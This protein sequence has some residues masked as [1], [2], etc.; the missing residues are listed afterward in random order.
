MAHPQ[1]LPARSDLPGIALALTIGVFAVVLTRLL[2]P[3]PLLSDVLLA[4][5]FGAVITNVRPLR[6]L[7]GLA[8]PGEEREA[9]R[10]ATGLRFVGKWV[11][12]LS[13]ILMGLKLQAKIFGASE[14]LV[15][16]MVAAASIP[17]AFLVAHA[18]AAPLGVRRPLGDLLAGG[19]M[20]CGASAVNALAPVVGARREE[21]GVAIG[22]V[23]LFSVVALVAFHPIATL[24][25]LD[26]AHAGL[27]S[28]LA[29]NDLSSAV[30]VGQQM[31]EAGGTMA[32][33][34][35]SSRIVLMA[36]ML[37]VLSL[38]RR[39]AAPGA[40]VGKRALDQLPGFLLG[41]VA[42]AAARAAIDRLAPSSGAVAAVLSGNRLVVDVLMAT[43]TASI[44]LHLEGGR[45]LASGWR[46][47]AVGGATA[48]WMA[49]LTLAMITLASRGATTAAAV[50]GG[51]C[52]V[53][54]GLA[55]RAKAGPRA[56]VRLV[57]QRYAAGDALTVAEASLLLDRLD[58]E[59]A[60][61][62]DALRRVLRLLQPS[63]GELIPVRASPLAHGVGCRWATF[64]EGASG[65]ALVAVCRDPGSA[66]PIHAHPHRLLGKSIEGI[67]EE[68]RFA[69]VGEG[70]L[71]LVERKALTHGDLVETDGLATPH[72]VRALGDHHTIDMQLRGPESGSPGRRWQELDAVD[73]ERLA[74]G[75]EVV[76]RTEIDDRPGQSGDGAAAGRL[77]QATPG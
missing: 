5:A 55:Y 2:P 34:A 36:P 70:R 54:A 48:A 56:E 33:A 14:L 67:L 18:V 6:R 26:A 19:T 44:G 71:R 32:A 27:W 76:T 24:V 12:R 40:D 61:D 3:S 57:K 20:I 60:L 68:L 73:Y 30:A 72:L 43:V 64:W 35:K 10:Y 29:V 38:M 53:A 16:G 39:R 9:D 50:L 17:S 52:V 41:Y 31:G 65:W 66:T 63:I 25:G 4:L 37:V 15:L 22:A 13:I 75:A 28:G 45:L 7:A 23:F 42:L 11:L 51:V 74:I 69:V 77:P 1:W 8:P 59:G 46:A 49:T 21:Q 58:H 62:D 47:L